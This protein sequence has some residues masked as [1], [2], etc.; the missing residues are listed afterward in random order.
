MVLNI[1]CLFFITDLTLEGN[2]PIVGVVFLDEADLSSPRPSLQGESNIDISSK[3]CYYATQYG[4][5]TA[6]VIV[7]MIQDKANTSDSAIFY[8]YHNIFYTC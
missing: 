7:I 8:S 5:Q 6:H 3:L 1:S 4:A 2:T